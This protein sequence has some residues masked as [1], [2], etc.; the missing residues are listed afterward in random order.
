M[1]SNLE[2]IKL[3]IE[4]A[5][6]VRHERL[7]KADLAFMVFADDV[8]FRRTSLAC[9]SPNTCLVALGWWVPAILSWFDLRQTLRRL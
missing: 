1:S 9:F 6:D 4:V 8:D 2:A 7:V 5:L 3:G